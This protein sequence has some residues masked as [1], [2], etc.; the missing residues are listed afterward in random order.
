MIHLLEKDILG[1]IDETYALLHYANIGK[2]LKDIFKYA[3]VSFD[4]TVIRTIIN[5]DIYFTY[6]DLQ[7]YIKANNCDYLIINLEILEGWNLICGINQIVKLA[8]NN[9]NV[10]FI[11]SS[12]ET[13]PAINVKTDF[14][15][16]LFFIMNSYNNLYELPNYTLH[17]KNVLDYYKMNAYSQHDYNKFMCELFFYISNTRRIKK[18]NFFNG[19]HKPHRLKCYDIIKK[20]NLLEDGFFS[21]LDYAEFKNDPVYNNQFVDFLDLNNLEEYTKYLQDF[22]IPYLCDSYHSDAN[23]F[24]PFLIPPQFAFQSYI[25]ITT[26]TFY[27]E[28]LSISISEKSY[29]AF[30]SFNI[31]LIFGMPL[32][33]KYLTDLGFDMF[34]DLFDT[35]IKF[36]KKDQYEQFEKNVKIIKNMSIKEIHS[37]YTSNLNRILHNYNNLTKIQKELNYKKILKYLNIQ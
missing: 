17:N 7:N 23:I 22:K 33:N 20:N 2:I 6:D 24:V 27:S 14:A 1:N 37:F 30:H 15:E 35:S 11:V 25:S 34:D 19:I 21:Y 9:N 16:N 26:E 18:Y 3:N 31:P 13:Y 29:K 4:E 12:Y 36:S 8:K 10:K 32:A 28:N 5:K